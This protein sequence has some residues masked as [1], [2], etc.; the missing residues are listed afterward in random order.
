MSTRTAT[1]PPTNP[2]LWHLLLARGHPDA[3]WYLLAEGIPLS[4][5]HAGHILSKLKRQ[6]A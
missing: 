2:R 4:D 6:A 3:G 5:R 1:A